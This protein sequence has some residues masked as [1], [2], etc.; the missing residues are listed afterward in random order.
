M[1]VNP[2]ARTTAKLVLTV[3]AMFCFAI[4]VMPPLYD[5]FCEITGIGGKTAGK[6][7]AGQFSA[8]LD[9]EV[10]VQFV[11]TNNGNMPW[12]FTAVEHEVKVNP[13]QSTAVEF[14]A[15]NSTGR[16]MVAQAIPNI[17]PN[18]AAG[19]FHKTECFCFNRQALKPGEETK[20]GLAFVVDPE[21]PDSVHTITLSYTLFDIT[22]YAADAVA[23]SD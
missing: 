21:L 5:V 23:I 9:R 17:S 3:L 6:Y 14:Y 8:Q 1:P 16:A 20:L 19:F 22:E 4:F 2:T 7:E 18:N 13:G 12:Q 15:K 10:K 11:T